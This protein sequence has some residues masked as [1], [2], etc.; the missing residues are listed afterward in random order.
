MF[1]TFEGIEGAGKGTLISFVAKW[2]E[3]NHKTF[4]ST[5]E[6][7]GSQLGSRLRAI[8]LD[9]SSRIVPDAEMFLYLADR[10]Q[11]VA[12]VIRPALD[13][14]TIVLC[15]RYADSNIVYQGYGRGLD[16]EELYELNNRAVR[17][18]W[19]NITF[20]LDL[21]PET[22]LERALKR[23]E[24]LGITETEG[25][26]EAENLAFHSRIRDGFLTWAH[27]HGERFV[28]LDACAEPEDVW[29]QALSRLEQIL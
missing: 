13:S 16:V 12:E 1:I 15:D 19:P 26:F 7:G 21:P 24:A 23:N 10:A 3:T 4:I 6:P 29:R 14:N 27:R 11:H 17:N 5:R 18:V 9:A 25:R 8:L 28:V 2:L 22:G 20:L